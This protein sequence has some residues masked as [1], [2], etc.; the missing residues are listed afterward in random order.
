MRPLHK[1][2]Q[3]TPAMRTATMADVGDGKQRGPYISRSH[4]PA[5]LTGKQPPLSSSLPSDQ[6]PKGRIH[7]AE[8]S[9]PGSG[10]LLRW[11]RV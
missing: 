9:L 7:A 5:L 2:E 11:R 10:G 8:V 4:L 6:L 1:M 3:G